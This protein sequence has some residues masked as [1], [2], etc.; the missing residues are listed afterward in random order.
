MNQ[1]A[2]LLDLLSRLGPD[3]RAVIT[4][5]ARRLVQGEKA[6]GPLDLKRDRRNWK[7]EASEEL[8]DACVYLACATINNPSSKGEAK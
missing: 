7:R 1:D 3:E 2:E 5:I 4:Y 8:L 6:Y